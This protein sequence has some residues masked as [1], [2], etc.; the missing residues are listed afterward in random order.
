LVGGGAAGS[1]EAH[2]VA[3]M[4]LAVVAS[5]LFGKSWTPFARL[6]L[7]TVVPLTAALSVV[8]IWLATR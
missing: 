7:L 1:D 4:A 5:V 8:M 2:D 6:F 3:D